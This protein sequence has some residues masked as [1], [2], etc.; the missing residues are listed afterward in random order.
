AAENNHLEAVEELLGAGAN[1]SLRTIENNNRSPLDVAA[2]RGHADVLKTLL[3][4]DSN[5][6][7]ATNHHGWGAL[8]HAASV[9]GPVRDNGDA[10]RALLE[11]GADVEVKTTGSCSTPLHVAANRRRTSDG[12]IRALLE[13]SGNVNVRTRRDDTPL[14][15]ACKCSSVTGVDLLL[16]WG[17]DE[18]LTNKVGKT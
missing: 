13:G 7:N 10:V 15:Q 4:K 16:R 17:A 6:V 14:H 3:E 8:H 5:E 11:A 2:N 9:D 1:Y 18:K 12:T